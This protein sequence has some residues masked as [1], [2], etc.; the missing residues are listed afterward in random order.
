[1][2]S[3]YPPQT[4]V[5]RMNGDNR[6]EGLSTTPEPSRNA[7]SGSPDLF[8]PFS[9][10]HSQMEMPKQVTSPWGCGNRCEGQWPGPQAG[11]GLGW[12]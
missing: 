6:Q 8:L 1:M 2:E 7:A 9:K 10:I 3:S 4:K 12:V 5:V 11:P